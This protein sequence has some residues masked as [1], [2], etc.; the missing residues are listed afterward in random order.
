M[1]LEYKRTIQKSDFVKQGV[2][3]N[4]IL[5]RSLKRLFKFIKAT[6]KSYEIAK[7]INKTVFKRKFYICCFGNPN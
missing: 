1:K 7:Q 3:F 6:A 5:L 4:N 2:I